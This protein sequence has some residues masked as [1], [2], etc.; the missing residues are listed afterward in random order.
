MSHAAPSSTYALDVH[1][2]PRS[3]ISFCTP[4][5]LRIVPLPLRTCAARVP[6]VRDHTH[7]THAPTTCT[8]TVAA[9]HPRSH[10][11]HGPTH[12]R[13]LALGRIWTGHNVIHVGRMHG[14]SLLGHLYLCTRST[15]TIRI[16]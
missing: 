12:R 16:V 10:G 8:C 15:S 2:P 6:D 3:T 14:M 5:L 9:S 7:S 11:T 13:T 1:C 4:Q